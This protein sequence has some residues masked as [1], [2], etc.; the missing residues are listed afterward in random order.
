MLSFEGSD[1]T[2][3]VFELVASFPVVVRCLQDVNDHKAI[4]MSIDKTVFIKI[5]DMSGGQPNNLWFT[6]AASAKYSLTPA[7]RQAGY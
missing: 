1:T 6:E 5:K 2:A 7:Y 4:K 3:P